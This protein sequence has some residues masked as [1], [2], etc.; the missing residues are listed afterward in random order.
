M[1][2]DESTRNIVLCF[3]G[4]GDWVAV[5]ETNVAKIFG[6]LDQEAQEVFYDGG[7]GTLTN[8]AALTG[9]QRTALRLID[10]GTAT[11]LSEKVLAGYLF[12]VDRFEKG[13]RVFLF[14]FSRG[15]F[16]AR[17]VAAMVHGFGLLRPDAKHL[18]PYL[19]QSLANAGSEGSK[20]QAAFEVARARI[21]DAFCLT[22]DAGVEIAFMGLFDTVSSVGI[23]GRFN[24]YPFTQHNESVRLTCHAVAMDEQRNAFPE[25]LMSRHQPGLTE[26]WFPGVHRDAGGGVEPGRAGVADAALGWIAAEAEAAGLLLTPAGRFPEFDPEKPWPKLQPNLPAW[27]PYVVLGLYPMKFFSKRFLRYRL[28]WPNFRHIRTIPENALI[29]EIARIAPKDPRTGRW[30]DNWPKNPTY[31]VSPR[32]VQPLSEVSAM[33]GY[34][35]REVVTSAVDLA[36]IVLGLAWLLLVWNSSV[37]SPFGDS[38]PSLTKLFVAIVFLLTLGAQSVAQKTAMRLPLWLR[39]QSSPILAF[40]TLVVVGAAVAGFGSAWRLAWIGAGLGVPIWMLAQLGSGLTLRMDRTLAIFFHAFLVSGLALGAL[41][42]GDGILRLGFLQVPPFAPEVWRG[43]CEAAAVAVGV[44]S[45]RTI[46]MERRMLGLTE[47][48]AP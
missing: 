42:A 23:V 37:G 12:L 3:D 26:V 13:D 17:L 33:T 24:T 19:W 45:V 39:P 41:A 27:D 16:T 15:A 29:H 44:S 20:Q 8:S 35:M 6:A 5:D 38:W 7:V 43:L 48:K 28:Y 21:K 18:A 30:P 32:R 1:A 2:N 25:Q 40:A 9:V 34:A 36:G 11:G 14:G 46:L 22:K 10:L 4:T 31:Y 47:A